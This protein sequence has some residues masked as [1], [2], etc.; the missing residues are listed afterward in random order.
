MPFV[1]QKSLHLLG[2]ALCCLEEPILVACL[3]AE[4][5]IPDKVMW[6]SLLG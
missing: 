4:R 3:V 1:L 6:Q 2:G 5:C